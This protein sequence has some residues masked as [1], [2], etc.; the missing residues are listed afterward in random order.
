MRIPLLDLKAQYAR[1]KAE[2][3]PA[4]DRVIESQ[5]FILGPEV[6][7]LE[8][9]FAAYTGVPFAVGVS[10]GTDALL[11]SLMALDIKPG[12]EVITT[13]FSFFA[14]AGVIARLGAIP[15]FVDIDPLT[16]NIDPLLV[17]TAVTK[18]TRA[19]I[20]VHLFGQCADM[21]PILGTSRRLG[22][23][24]IED[25][26]QATG[27]E[28]KGRKA[29]ALGDIGAFSFF[30]SKNLGAFG[31]GG[32]VVMCDAALH[33][34]IRLL[35]QHGSGKTYHHKY[36]GGNFR[37]DALQAAVLSVKFKHL[38][39][40]ADARRANATYYTRRFSESGLVDRGVIIPPIEA[41][42]LAPPSNDSRHV[43]NQYTLRARD[44]DGLMSHLK[45]NG[46]SSAIYYPV[47][48]HFQECFMGLGYKKGNFPNAEKA[49]AEVLS[50]PVYPELTEEQ[51]DF[52]VRSIISF[53]LS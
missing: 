24:V 39:G 32:M 9:E 22:I 53:Y 47:P 17:A 50:I 27:A 49:A 35:R 46:I 12:D 33:E 23:P 15:V 4:L 40:W 3:R 14:T 48:L 42:T 36:V 38:D 19:I 28:Y 30:P 52:V 1:I 25:A 43:F 16:F 44:R 34:K 45:D 21:D 20:P 7:A 13:P 37:L 29:G 11:V 51:Q 18:K 31:D 2:I 26:C 8:G 41:D 6:E 10:S 5:S